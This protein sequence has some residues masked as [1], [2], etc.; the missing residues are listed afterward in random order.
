MKKWTFVFLVLALLTIVVAP[1]E[2]PFTEISAPVYFDENTIITPQALDRYVPDYQYCVVYVKVV[3]TQQD[4][5]VV[6]TVI[7]PAAFKIFYKV[8][9]HKSDGIYSAVQFVH[10]DAPRL[11]T[12]GYDLYDL[13]I[14]LEHISQPTNLTTSVTDTSWSITIAGGSMRVTYN[15]IIYINA[16]GEQVGAE[17]T[18]QTRA[19]YHTM[20]GT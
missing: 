5:S 8:A 12:N 11:S 7:S 9:V 4:G 6:E 16:N 17:Q 19:Y 20:S 15:S 14:S 2:I 3:T 13:D 10:K 18:T 1:A